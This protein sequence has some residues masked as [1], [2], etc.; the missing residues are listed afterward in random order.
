MKITLNLLLI[1]LF[2]MYENWLCIERQ[3]E[4]KI[5]QL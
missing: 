4:N 3:I 5:T 1:G 2:A